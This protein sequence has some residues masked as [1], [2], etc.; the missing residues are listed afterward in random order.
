MTAGA[1][2]RGHGTSDGAGRAVGP[3]ER[4]A[5]AKAP[6]D[7]EARTR[8]PWWALA[9]PALAFTLLLTLLVGAGS[10]PTTRQERH[11]VQQPLARVL[12]QI[13]ATLLG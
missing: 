7:R 11:P 10:A 2:I 3:R 12:R 9:L 1:P 13:E 6:R 4:S 8:L 5:S